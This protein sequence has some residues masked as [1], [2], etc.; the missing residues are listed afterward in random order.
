MKKITW[1]LMSWFSL[2]AFILQDAWADDSQTN[3]F[4][5]F[6]PRKNTLINIYEDQLETRSM[7]VFYDRLGPPAM[8]DWTTSRLTSGY[9][10]H[11]QYI[12]AGQGSMERS[13]MYSVRE[14]F[15]RSPMFGL[16]REKSEYMNN[17]IVGTIGNTAEGRLDTLSP[18][19]T[20]AQYALQEQL[21]LDG[22][23]QY[24]FRPFDGNPYGYLEFKGGNWLNMPLFYGLI[25]GHVDP[26]HN[27]KPTIDALLTFNTPFNSQLSTGATFDP[28]LIGSSR[29]DLGFSID[30]NHRFGKK[31]LDGS[32]FTSFTADAKG[33]G[34]VRA[35][36][37][38]PW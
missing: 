21:R 2:P 33:N 15:T 20:A 26:I 34:M 30:L 38:F 6:A 37:H 5:A 23:L 27:F 9:D 19:P 36:L 22:N 31:L 29:S 32:I 35:E 11:Q 7:T 8:L 28:T 17:L 24:G 18:T 25:R 1:F 10:I 13:F 4:S 14:T 12:N 3:D 16:I